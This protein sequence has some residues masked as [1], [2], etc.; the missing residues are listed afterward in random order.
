MIAI[1]RVR[2]RFLRP[3]AVLAGV[4]A[5]LLGIKA[6]MWSIAGLTFASGLLVSLRMKETNHGVSE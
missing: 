1:T 2:I 4:V 6:A 5:D 3:S